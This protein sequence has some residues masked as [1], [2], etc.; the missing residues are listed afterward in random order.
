MAME[1]TIGI[2]YATWHGQAEKVAARVADVFHMNGASATLLD[3]HRTSIDG[4]VIERYDAIVVVGSV[5][6]G[7]HPRVLL[8]FVRRKLTA[9]SLVPTAFLSV[10]GAAA[11]LLGV[12]EA[13]RYIQE[14]MVKSGWRP[15]VTLSVAGAIPY[16]K[17][18]FFTRLVMR[19]AS[20]IAGR[21]SDSS[22]DFEYT[23]WFAVE[24]FARKFLAE[25]GI[26]HHRTRAA[27]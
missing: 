13:E 26:D 10:S 1:K 23:N 9:L 20:R 8:E 11:P 5:H 25:L 18:G 2:I 16:T 12:A 17:Y 6:F 14:F 22:R 24:D 15:G 21:D 27:Q 3:A 4:V 19:F 7:R